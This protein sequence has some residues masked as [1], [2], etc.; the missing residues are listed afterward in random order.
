[1]F[2]EIKCLKLQSSVVLGDSIWQ[3]LNF[4]SVE[5]LNILELFVVN[6]IKKYSLAHYLI[7]GAPVGLETS[8]S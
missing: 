3:Y 1:M 7:L 2:N 6:H 8:I 4:S 5:V